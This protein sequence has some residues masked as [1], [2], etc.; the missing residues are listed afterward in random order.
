MAG[1]KPRA[2]TTDE[3][4]IVQRRCAFWARSVTRGHDS[5]G[6]E[7]EGACVDT[8]ETAPDAMTVAATSVVTESAAVETTGA[9]TAELAGA[10]TGSGNGTEAA[11]ST[12]EAEKRE[13]TEYPQSYPEYE[14]IVEPEPEEADGTRERERGRG[15]WK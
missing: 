3:T 10:C 13:S 12:A 6:G 7:R 9:K 2:L 1:E 5:S 14:L 11:A 4:Q 15:D 8:V